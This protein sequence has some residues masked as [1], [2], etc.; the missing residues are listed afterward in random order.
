[1]DNKTYLPPWAY[2]PLSFNANESISADMNG[3]APNHLFDMAVN[4]IPSQTDA[5]HE[6]S[7][8]TDEIASKL[9]DPMTRIRVSTDDS[10]HQM[11]SISVNHA[12]VD[13]GSISLF[14]SAWSRQYQLCRELGGA[15]ANKHKDVERPRVT[16]HHP[17][18]DVERKQNDEQTS[19]PNEWTMLLPSESAENPFVENNANIANE[20]TD[21]VSC[22]V[23]Y[24][25]R[26]QIEV[27]KKKSLQETNQLRQQQPDGK[28]GIRVPPYLSSNDALLGEVCKQLEATSVLLCMDW[29]PVLNRSTFF[30]Y[31]VLFLYLDLPCSSSAPA[32]CRNILGWNDSNGGGG[33]ASIVRDVSFVMWKMQNENKQGRT[34]LIWN[35]RTD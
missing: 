26:D 7:L 33:C 29:R 23:Y 4:C 5:C 27:M 24:R 31:A 9:G 6:S 32:A 21:D 18:F 15:E 1:V 30:G 3:V 22:T 11:I 20:A 17:I 16:F 19:I 2:V 25:S 8:A 12:L 35:S 13:A 34:D 28:L 14:M 10:K